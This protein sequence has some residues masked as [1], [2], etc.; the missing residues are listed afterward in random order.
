[1]RFEI[2]SP[3]SDLHSLYG[4]QAQ[5][6]HAEFE[7]CSCADVERESSLQKLGL[8]ADYLEMIVAG[9]EEMGHLEQIHEDG[10]G[11]EGLERV[12][13]DVRPL[14]ETP[15]EEDGVWGGQEQCE[16]CCEELGVGNGGAPDY[17]AQSCVGVL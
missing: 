3:S 1:M 2:L 7:D 9:A 17:G 5:Q 15:D 12:G 6:T 13:E 11:L 4:R 8:T 10:D 14:G 16:I